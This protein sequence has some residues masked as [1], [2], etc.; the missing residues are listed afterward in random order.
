M[1]DKKR[2]EPRLNYE[3]YYNLTG[4]ELNGMIDDTSVHEIDKKLAVLYEDMHIMDDSEMFEEIDKANRRHDS[5]GK[6]FIEKIN[7][8][9]TGQKEA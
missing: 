3:G 5:K 9:W 1:K 6:E 8:E 4:E 2:D 7:D